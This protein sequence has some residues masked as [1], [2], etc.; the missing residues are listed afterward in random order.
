ME[1]K[2]TFKTPYYLELKAYFTV[3][4]KDNGGLDGPLIGFRDNTMVSLVVY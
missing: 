1:C 4:H 3:E 2:Q